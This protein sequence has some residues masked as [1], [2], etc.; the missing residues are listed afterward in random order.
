MND[1][2][3]INYEADPETRERKKYESV[4]QCPDCLDY[5]HAVTGEVMPEPEWAECE[6]KVCMECV[7]LGE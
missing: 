1:P 7:E 5:Y 3:Y 4:L 6:M 2:R